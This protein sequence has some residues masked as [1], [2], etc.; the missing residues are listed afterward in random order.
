MS[1]MRVLIV[2]DEPLARERLRRLIEREPEVELVGECGNGTAAISRLSEGGVDI[3]FI[4]MEM[5]GANGLEVLA[6]MPTV[7]RPA[8]VFATAHE[9]FALDAFEVQA[10]DYLLKP[11]DRERFQIAL[12]RAREWRET[13]ARE[14]G[15]NGGNGGAGGSGEAPGR[16]SF[17]VDGR[18]VLLTPAEIDWVEAADNYVVLH[19]AA[20]PR[21]MVR[22]TM[23]AMERR[24][25]KERFLRANRSALVRIDEIKEVRPSAHGDYTLVLRKGAELPLSRSLRGKLDTLF[26]G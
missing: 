16:L 5:P 6:R 21:H 23:A 11:F 25:G 17:K 15:P 14:S 2:D 1:A 4:D 13:H 12:E 18:L 26:G 22:D 20:G 9:S 7:D 10:V 19:T 3:L 24:L 8:V